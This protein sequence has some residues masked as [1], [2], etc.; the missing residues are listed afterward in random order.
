MMNTLVSPRRGL[1]T[2]AQ[3]LLTAFVEESFDEVSTPLRSPLTSRHARRDRLEE[4]EAP[5]FGSPTQAPRP[6]RAN[7]VS[8]NPPSAAIAAITG[9]NPVATIQTANT[10]AIALLDTA[11]RDLQDIRRRIIAGAAPATTVPEA[12]RTSLNGRFRLNANDRSI[13][14]GTGARSVLVLIRRLRGS[15]QILADG[16]MRYVCLGRANVDFTLGGRRCQGSACTGETRAV[17]CGGIS[18]IVL[19]RPW[20]GDTLDDQAG[21]LLHECFHI[22]FGFIRDAGNFANAHCYEHLVLQLNGLTVQAGFAAS[23]PV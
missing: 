21:T 23:C 16:W 3:S 5:D 20:W 17:A 13:W 1:H 18:Q 4:L 22:Y 14:T 12:M 8:C 2:D 9:P 19:C 11:I 7:F 6:I 15:R 10:R